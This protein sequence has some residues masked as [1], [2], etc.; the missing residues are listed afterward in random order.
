MRCQAKKKLKVKLRFFGCEKILQRSRSPIKIFI[1]RR[2]L[3]T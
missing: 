3:A 1:K 2:E